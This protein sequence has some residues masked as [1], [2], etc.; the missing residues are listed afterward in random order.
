MNIKHTRMI[1]GFIIAITS[2][3]AC[4]KNESVAPQLSVSPTTI[5]FPAEGDTLDVSVDCDAQ[6]SI[7]NP[8]STW[9]HLSKQQAI[10]AA[11]P[12]N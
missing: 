8:A 4:K 3:I 12:S 10:V 5:S 9:L 11:R 7:A 1:L 6:W 2:L